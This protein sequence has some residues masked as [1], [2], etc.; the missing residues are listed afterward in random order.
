MPT[1]RAVELE[2]RHG[3]SVLRSEVRRVTHRRLVRWL[4][5]AGAALYAGILV[6]SWFQYEKTTPAALERAEQRMHEII[7]EQEAYRQDCLRHIPSDEDPELACGSPMTVDQLG[8]P[9]DFLAHQPYSL[10]SELP[11][12]SLGMA[13]VV[14]AVGFL[15]G[16]TAIGAEWS[17]KT[18]MALLFWEP[19]RLRVLG[20]KVGVAAG[21]LAVLAVLSQALLIP[22]AYVFGNAKGTTDVAAGFWGD[23]LAQQA[24][25]V[26]LVVLVGLIGFGI[27][28]LVRNTGA[29]LGAGFVYFVFEIIALNLWQ[30]L[31]PWLLTTNAGALVTKGG[32]T[33]YWGSGEPTVDA[34]G[35][36]V[37]GREYVMT[38]LHGGLVIG[39][40]ALAL[41][42]AGG[43]L[44]KRRDLT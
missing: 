37:S 13:A 42:L 10:G 32:L 15:L 33:V 14:A 29:A 30:W 43:Y 16:A 24:R 20:T 35:N 26:L 28:N 7:D 40:V 4:V 31:Q 11:A 38:N 21:G 25:C 22:I 18:L 34:G 19:R 6:I 12:F 17:Q 8:E 41:L 9:Q 36:L 27:A 1:A 2:P 3:G 5:L 39:A 23:L 44:F